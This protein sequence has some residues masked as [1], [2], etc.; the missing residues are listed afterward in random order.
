MK[1]LFLDVDGVLNCTDTFRR[2]HAAWEATGE[3]FKDPIRFGWPL[4]HLDENL[5]PLLNPICEQ[6][7]CNIV[8]SSTWRN[9]CQLSEFKGW[10]KQKGFAY[11]DKI[12]DVTPTLNLSTQEDQRGLEIKQWLSN[13]P[14]VIAY[15]ILDDDGF[16]II[17]IHPN[18]Y[19]HVRFDEGL[20]T[21]EVK[22][23]IAMLNK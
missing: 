17:G 1:I 22:F 7:G 16:D 10:L 19:V 23:A 9:L 6:T 18:N 13:K 5:V 2:R 11:S 21:E 12:I 14:E 8:V 4:G 15:C 3:E 20:T